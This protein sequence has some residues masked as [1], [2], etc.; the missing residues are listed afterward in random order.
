[1]FWEQHVG[2]KRSFPWRYNTESKL[3]KKHPDIQK[4]NN[5]L[6][7][8]IK[9]RTSRGTLSWLWANNYNCFTLISKGVR[10]PRN[11]QVFVV[12]V[13]YSKHKRLSKWC[14]DMFHCCST[15]DLVLDLL[16]GDTTP[17]LGHASIHIWNRYISDELPNLRHICN[18]PISHEPSKSW[19]AKT[20]HIMW[21]VVQL[22]NIYLL[23][24]YYWTIEDE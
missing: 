3:N 19:N 5:I 22:I 4:L 21:A 14:L 24:L 6:V 20:A 7:Y 17:H 15:L 23:S 9:W 11:L 10:F 12:H 16:H 18:R 1:M 13:V 2:Y 8:N